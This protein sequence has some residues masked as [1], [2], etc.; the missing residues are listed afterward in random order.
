MTF[1]KRLYD[2]TLAKAAHRHAER[3]L[4]FISFIE[5]SVFPIPPDVMLLPMCLARRERCLRYAGICTLASVVGGLAGYGIGYFFW[6]AVGEPIIAFYGYEAQ[7]AEFQ[8][9]FDDYGA[10]LVFLFGLTFFPYKVI[11]LAAGV[12]AMDPLAF[13]VASIAARAPRFYVEAALLWKFGAP[14]R[15]FIERRLTLLT[16][17]FA[18]L[19]VGGFVLIKL[20]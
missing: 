6:Q 9:R 1:M 7:F 8:T 10:L 16:T 4:A 11:T 13:L 15:D 17:L 2:W 20:A 14:I 19:L 12:A 3:W 18:I 5:S